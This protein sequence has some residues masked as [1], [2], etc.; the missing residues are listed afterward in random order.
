MGSPHRHLSATVRWI[1]PTVALAALISLASP[2][3]AQLNQPLHDDGWILAAVHAPGLHGSIWRTDLWIYVD[4]DSGGGFNLRFCRSGEDGSE[5]QY[6]RFEMLGGQ[7][8]LYLEDVV[9]QFLGVG[10]SAWLG[11]IH[12]MS[13]RNVQVWARVYSISPDG[14][15]SYGQLI[16]GI[17]TAHMSP[18][19]RPWN[20]DDHQWLYALKHTPDGRY[21]VNIGIVNPTAVPSQY[22]VSIY[23]AAVEN[24]ATGGEDIDL[25]IPPFS[26]VQLS[27]PFAGANGGDWSAAV[28]RVTCGTEGGGTFAYA[29]V[30]DN[31]TNDAFFVRGVKRY[32]QSQMPGLNC[33]A[34]TDGWV[35]AAAHAPGLHGSIW[36]TDLWIW[37]DNP[38]EHPV[39]LYFEETGKDGT[40]VQG[41]QVEAAPDAEVVYIEDAVDHFLHVGDGSWVGAI[42]Y[43]SDAPVQVWARVYSI[44]A[45]GSASYGQM[46]E[47]IPT[48]DASPAPPANSSTK[49]YQWMVAA[50]H[51]TDGRYRVNVGIVN[52][53]ATAGQFYV[54]MFTGDAA[55][56]DETI[57]PIM[58]P[59]HSMVQTSDAFSAVD[60]GDWSDK[61]IRVA[62]STEGTTAFAYLSVVDN[63]TND[64][65]FVRGIKLLSYPEP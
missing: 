42:H 61:I 32:D 58:V 33:T 18:D 41:F 4:T 63:A 26:M 19:Q 9:D 6:F 35:L 2:C 22:G 27:D 46:I 12:Y 21:R 62:P 53:S 13:S 5:A 25:E 55:D 47:G 54:E 59:A 60:G 48:S 24:M 23:D 52:P 49:D 57:G 8:V 45:D 65:Y 1:V 16:E 44:S 10:D 28:V 34:H 30:V 14:S 40:R 31:A 43:R 36:R 20:P 3:S 15:K 38:A 39:K 11:A 29:S 37:A 7:R 56:R 50:R 17:P 51:T 64:A